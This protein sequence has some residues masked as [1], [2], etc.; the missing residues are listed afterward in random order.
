MSTNSCDGYMVHPDEPCSHHGTISQLGI[1]LHAYTWRYN[2]LPE[3]G[4]VDSQ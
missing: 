2:F 3:W 4:V 1:Y